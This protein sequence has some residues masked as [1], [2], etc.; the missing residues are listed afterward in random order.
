MPPRQY[1]LYMP[2]NMGFADR[3]AAYHRILDPYPSDNKKAKAYLAKKGF[4]TGE[5]KADPI[6]VCASK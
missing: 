6:V 2:G 3:A 4:G 5:G 1:D